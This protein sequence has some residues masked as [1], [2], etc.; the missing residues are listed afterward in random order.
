MDVSNDAKEIVYYQKPD[1]YNIETNSK[2]N[3]NS[4]YLV[5][6]DV[7]YIK[8][9]QNDKYVFYAVGDIPFFWTDEYRL[10]FYIADI[11]TGNKI[12]LDKWEKGDTFYGIGW[13]MEL[14]G[15]LQKLQW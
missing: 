15:R 8:F 12:R 9:S 3:V 6:Q 11:K 10:T 7:V 13:Q 2:T 4:Q 14:V 5:W 1:I